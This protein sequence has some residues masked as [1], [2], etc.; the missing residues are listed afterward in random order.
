MPHS[1]KRRSL[2][3]AL[4]LLLLLGLSL[5]FGFRT[6][7]AS[8][9]RATALRDELTEPSAALSPEQRRRRFQKL[10]QAIAELSPRERQAFWADRRRQFQ[11][12]LD[13]FFH[14]P[15]QEQVAVLNAEMDRMNAFRRG[16]AGP[17]ADRQG[18]GWTTGL[19]EEDLQRR[20]KQWLDLTTAEERALV[21]EY[22]GML[23][24]QQQQTG[25]GGSSP[26]GIEPP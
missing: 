7:D 5:R 15:R 20:Q 8:L 24:Q 16:G 2:L 6:S 1:R 9:A 18:P 3:A 4:I 10:S 21:A 19:S 17:T 23:S 11:D 13:D 26:W 12:W 25:Q 14:S 22:L